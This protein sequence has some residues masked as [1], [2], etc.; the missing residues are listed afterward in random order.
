[1]SIIKIF[2]KVKKTFYKRLQLSCK[3]FDKK[4]SAIYRSEKTV[5]LKGKNISSYKITL[6]LAENL[7]YRLFPST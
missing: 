3:F 7:I 1:M 6:S 5:F 2:L 4:Q